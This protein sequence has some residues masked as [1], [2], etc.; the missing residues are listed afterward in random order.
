[1]ARIASYLALNKNGFP[2]GRMR[3]R[4]RIEALSGTQ[5]ASG[6]EII[7]WSEVGTYWGDV[8]PVDGRELDIG[9]QPN[10]EISAIFIM[11]R[12]ANIQAK[13]RAIYLGDA[14]DIKLPPLDVDSRHKWM[15]LLCSTGVN[16]G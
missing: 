16:D 11:R 10:A 3:H 4:I 13:M 5:S 2:A 14:Y 8:I 7:D 6:E 9:D 15:L 1:M 12:N